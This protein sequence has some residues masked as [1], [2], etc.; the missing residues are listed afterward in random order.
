[1]ALYD[2]EL[3]ILRATAVSAVPLDANQQKALA[4]RLSDRMDARVILTCSVDPDLIGGLRVLIGDQV[5]DSSI[6]TQLDTL[7]KRLIYA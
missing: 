3:G 6:H 7:K 5:F 2:D 4:Q 1:M